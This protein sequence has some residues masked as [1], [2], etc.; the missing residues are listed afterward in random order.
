RLP[1]EPSRRFT[2]KPS[3]AELLG[4]TFIADGVDE[5]LTA[6]RENLRFGASQIK[7]MAG[8]GTSSA[9]DPIDVTQYTLEEMRAAVN[10]AADWN[11]YVAVH[12]YTPRSVRRAI[13]AGVKV[14]E[15]GQLLDDA[16]LR[17]MA[18]KG[19][20]LSGQWLVEDTPDMAPERREKRRDIVAN[21]ARLLRSAKRLGVKLAWGTDFLFEPDLNEQQN[22]YLLKLKAIFTPAELLRLATHGNAQ[23]LALSGPR[24]PYQGT[25]GV[26]EIGALADLLVVRGDPLADIDLLGDPDRNFTVIMKG[27]VVHKNVP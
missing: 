19:V 26:V 16:T 23:L 15:H 24:A 2:G 25:L 21:N 3:R 13:A 18:Q 5:V 10:A 11:T 14:I 8:G 6:T 12:A 9:Y 1:N 4:A 22:A 20:W 27:G 17:V 7:L